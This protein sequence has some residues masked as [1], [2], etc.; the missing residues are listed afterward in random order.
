VGK[1]VSARDM[2]QIGRRPMVPPERPPVPEAPPSPASDSGAS[3]LVDSA[4]NHLVDQ[5]TSTLADSGTSQLNDS[6]TNQLVPQ[7]YQRATFFLTPDQRRWLKDTAHNLSAPGL[8][9]SDVVRLAVSRLRA[10]IEAEGVDLVDALTA[11]A[12]AEAATHPGR[13]NRGLPP[14]H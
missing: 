11:Q 12:H 1:T 6:A 10:D 2:L 13:R 9:A 8:S 3:A 4:P 5:S 7:S 14:R